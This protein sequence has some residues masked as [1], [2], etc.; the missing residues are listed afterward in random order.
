VAERSRLGRSAAIVVGSSGALKIVGAA[1]G[2]LVARLLGP[3]DRGVYGV[4]SAIALFGGLAG[5]M[6]L[7]VWAARQ[8][9]A[10]SQ[11][12]VVASELDRHLRRLLIGGAVAAVAVGAAGIVIPKADALLALLSL[13]FVVGWSCFLLE[14]GWVLGRDH[15]GRY[16]TA[17]VVSV[18]G[19]SAAIAALMAAGGAGLT[20]VVGVAS[21]G[22]WLPMVVLHIQR[23]RE[24]RG[25]G[26]VGPSPTVT[27]Q[28]FALGA[29]VAVGELVAGAMQRAD[30]I[31]LAV[32][33]TSGEAGL[34]VAAATLTELIWFAPNAL[35]QVLLP[36]RAGAERSSLDPTP[37]RLAVMLTMV[38]GIVVTLTSPWLV[39]VLFGD[40][41]RGSVRVVPWL[42]AAAV[43]LTAWRLLVVDVVT[44]NR[45]M[46]K[47]RSATVGL[48]VMLAADLVLIPLAGI[49][50][51]GI[52]ALVGY[53]AA[54][55]SLLNAWRR[56]PG[57]SLSELLRPSW[58]DYRAVA[59]AF[60][61]RA[62]DRGELAR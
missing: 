27:R 32:L 15:M 21:L 12:N 26:P 24:L 8:L 37:I 57:A 41:F 44:A 51:A 18:G 28:A 14:I 17:N 11:G 62:Q 3:A 1:G 43:A 47:L 35:A 60:R 58:N 10:R 45:S 6:G 5:A 33:A 54:M 42:A 19:Y 25:A 31:V 61:R 29:P 39:P 2:V 55:A 23:R 38:T 40:E 56:L 7:D 59:R 36:A 9:G 30:V 4:I 53:V 49:V 16:V 50:G 13:S 46:A 34:Y 22:R 20:W 48:V 52:A